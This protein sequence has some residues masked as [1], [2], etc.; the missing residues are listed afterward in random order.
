LIVQTDYD[1]NILYQR[2][3]H[4]WLH[5]DFEK[6]VKPKI[7]PLK[8]S[9]GTKPEAALQ[10]ASTGVKALDHIGLVDHPHHLQSTFTV[11]SNFP[12]TL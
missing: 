1:T 7:E 4:V 2:V 11:E 6:E 10:S 3:I 12:S 9:K 8:P 5:A